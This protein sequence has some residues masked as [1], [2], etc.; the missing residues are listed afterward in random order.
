MGEDNKRDVSINLAYQDIKNLD[1]VRFLKK[2]LNNRDIAKY[3]IF[4]IVESEDIK[5]F[6]IVEDFI[7]TFKSLGVRIA[8]DD[9]GTGY[10]NFTHIMSLKPDY[11][12]IDGSLIKNIG[13]N[14]DSFELV[15]AIVQFSKEL[16]IKTI[17]EYVCSKE[18]FD[19]VFNLGVDEFQGYY[20]GKPSKSYSSFELP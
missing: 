2:M 9:F 8:I 14:K 17:A 1:L 5:D 20:F 11:L 12:K 19:I 4:E 6:E 3:I 15:K 10:S 7:K 13:T 16:N 18:I